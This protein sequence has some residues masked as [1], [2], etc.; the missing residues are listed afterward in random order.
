MQNNQDQGRKNAY[1]FQAAADLGNAME[2]TQ[3]NKFHT[4]G[5]T[6]F[7]AEEANA[8]ADRWRGRTVDQVGTGNARNGA[9]R[10]V[11]GV[12]VQTKYFGSANRTLNA[13]FD[14]AG[15]YRYEGQLLEVPSDQYAECLSLME[16]KIEQGKVPGVTDPAEAITIVKK[17][18]VSY[19]QA[20]NIA[21]AG[22]IDSLLFDARNQCVSSTY[23][24]G[25]SFLVNFA[26][27]KWDGKPAGQAAEQALALGLSS[28]ASSFLTGIVARQILRSRTVAMSVPLMKSG[29]KVVYST[30]LGKAFV[31]KVAQASLGKVVT[32]AA[33]VNHVSKLLRTNVVTGIV[34][35]VVISGP[36]F[37]RAAFSKNI[38]WAQFSKNFTVGAAGVAGGTGGWMAGAAAGAALGSVVPVLGTGVGAATGGIVG[39]MLGG[40]VGTLASKKL[41]DQLVDDDAK[42]MLELL[43]GHL[44]VLAEDYL[45][46]QP[47][48]EQLLPRL[49]E[50]ITAELLRDMY[51]SSDRRALVFGALEPLFEEVAAKRTPVAAPP[52]HEVQGSLER[53]KRQALEAADAQAAAD[54]LERLAGLDLVSRRRLEA[55][56][57]RT[58][59]ELATMQDAHVQRITG[60][61]GTA[62]QILRRNIDEHVTA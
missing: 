9:D 4:K 30:G 36:D 14:D 57:V 15:N 62:L 38:S 26:R 12:A 43:Q 42:E 11:D 2:R 47:E 50:K 39:S 22:N 18:E 3:L 8:A 28:G 17:G 44:R 41:L 53:F 16:K 45:L 24:F 5:G 60:M 54:F 19:R 49:Q 21:R 31:H 55:A 34:T 51:G 40:T 59:G 33:A 61:S 37:Y 13:A 25:L 6:G 46:T 1:D 20:R 48:V 58:V 56:Q 35:T 23:A 29:V 52:A 10:I 27:L 7:A 32:G